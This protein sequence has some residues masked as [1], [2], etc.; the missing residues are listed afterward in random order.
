MP[1]NNKKIIMM[2]KMV[3]VCV[4]MMLLLLASKP[5][6]AQPINFS[7]LLS[8]TLDTVSKELFKHGEIIL[9]DHY[10]TL[11]RRPFIKSWELHYRTKIHCPGWTPI[12]GKGTSDW[13]PARSELDATRDYVRQ[14]LQQGFI[15]QEQAD[16]WI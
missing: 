1:V 2:D 4:P 9:F 15:T 16:P 12:I 7:E 8:G 14:A 3:C 13:N 10:C 11:S 6:Q 5:N